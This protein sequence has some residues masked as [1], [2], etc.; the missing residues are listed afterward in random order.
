MTIKE[1]NEKDKKKKNSKGEES[2]AAE[3]I[4][5]NFDCF[6]QSPSIGRERRVIEI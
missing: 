4:L 3:L 5:K 6:I 2:L 1:T